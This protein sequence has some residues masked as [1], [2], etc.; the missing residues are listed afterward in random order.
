M[1]SPPNPAVVPTVTSEY[2]FFLPLSERLWPPARWKA[3]G[4]LLGSCAPGIVGH[5]FWPKSL[6]TTG[7]HQRQTVGEPTTLHLIRPTAL[8]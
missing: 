7:S 4:L 3:Q 8:G 2:L 5:R 1:A 6:D